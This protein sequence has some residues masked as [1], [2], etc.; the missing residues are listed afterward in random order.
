[1]KTS[2]WRIRLVARCLI[3]L[4]ALPFG[5]NSA[6]RAQE[7]PSATTGRGNALESQ[8][9]QSSPNQ[10]GKSADRATLL[11]EVLPDAPEAQA[12]QESSSQAG[13]ESQSAGDTKPLGTAAAPYT[14]PTGVTGSRPAGAVIAPARQRRV[15]AILISVGVIA[16]AG[17]AIGTVAGLSH[18]SPSRAN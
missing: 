15:R 16:A 10:A 1:M 8:A 5:L 12:A 6:A 13:A 3:V 4:L 7:A 17:I 9:Q 11:S 18:A 2:S 14:K